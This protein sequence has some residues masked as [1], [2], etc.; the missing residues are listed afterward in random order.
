MGVGAD[1]KIVGADGFSSRLQS[2]ADA[3]VFGI[4]RDVRRQDR[5]KLQKAFNAGLQPRLALLRA[6]MAQLGRDNDAGVD[7]PVADPLDVVSGGA[8]RVAQKRAEDVGVQQI[9]AHSTSSG[10]VG[11]SEMSGSWSS[12]AS[13]PSFFH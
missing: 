6:A 7:F 4:G 8:I 3:A 1:Q 5:N 11:V 13:G 9:A 10:A 2:G 12:G